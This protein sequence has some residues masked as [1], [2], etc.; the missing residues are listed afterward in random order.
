M[1]LDGIRVQHAGL[2]QAA[3]DLYDTVKKIDARM[4]DL[5]SDLERLRSGWAGNARASYDQ[6]K[7]KWDWAIQEMKDLLDETSKSVYQ[8]NQEYMDADKR[9]AQAFQI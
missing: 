4:N 3:A 9:G 5:E 6:A 2:D 8:S 7:L 1:N